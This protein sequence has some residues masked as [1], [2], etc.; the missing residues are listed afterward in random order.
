MR[1]SRLTPTPEA[2]PF[3][4]SLVRRLRAMADEFDDVGRYY[5]RYASDRNKLYST[6]AHH[7]AAQLR[8]VAINVQRGTFTQQQGFLWLRAAWRIISAIG[9]QNIA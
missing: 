7:A 5:A 9:R 6:Q 2:V 3:A 8:T 1:M 4:V